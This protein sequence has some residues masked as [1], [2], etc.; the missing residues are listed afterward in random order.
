MRVKLLLVFVVAI[1]FLVAPPAFAVYGGGGSGAC[2]VCAGGYDAA[3]RT[4]ILNCANANDGEWGSSECTIS[5]STQKSFVPDDSTNYGSCN[6]D[7]TKNM[8]LTIVVT[9]N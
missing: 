3:T 9:P 4:T 5:C 7:D 2:Q 8:C 1:A 6:C